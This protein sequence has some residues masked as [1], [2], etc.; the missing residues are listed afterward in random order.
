MRRHFATL[1]ITFLTVLVVLLIAMAFRPDWRRAGVRMEIGQR[2]FNAG[3]YDRA[4]EMCDTVLQAIPS[5]ARALHLRGLSH[6]RLGELDRALREY[7]A[8]IELDPRFFDAIND[9]GILLT[10][11]GRLEE[12]LADFRRLVAL[13][14]ISIS[15]RV[16]YAFALQKAGRTDEAVASLE[17][18]DEDQRD[19]TVQYLMASI[20]MAQQDWGSADQAFSAAIEI[21]SIDLKT[22]LNR[23]IARWRLGRHEEAISDL[24]RAASLDEDWMLQATIEELRRQINQSQSP[25]SVVRLP[26]AG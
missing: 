21:N 17:V 18:I 3:D 13:D 15:A 14:P 8:A 9:R 10:K 19:E 11:M 22:W 12:G 24:D 25:T 5:H 23:A 7:H 6:D 16:N 26:L 20:A 2:F 4:I 1:A